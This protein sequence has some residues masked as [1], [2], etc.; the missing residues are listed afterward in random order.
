MLVFL[1]YFERGLACLKGSKVKS[2]KRVSDHGEV[3]TGGRE[4]I[5]MLD[6]A[7][8]VTEP[9]D[10]WVRSQCLNTAKITY[11]CLLTLI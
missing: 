11:G 4:I 9:I 10:S 1:I 8:T 2:K 7:K 6:L 5:A 3:F